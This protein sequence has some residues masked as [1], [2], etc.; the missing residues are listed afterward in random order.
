MQL[1]AACNWAIKHGL[2]DS[3]PYDGMANEIP[4]YR[5]Q[6]EPKPNTLLKRS[7][8]GLFR[9]SKTTRGTGMGGVTQVVVTITMHRLSSSYFLQDAGHLRRSV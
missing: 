9:L 4:K 1:N 2:I 7:D 5:Y 8:I 3:N 6:L